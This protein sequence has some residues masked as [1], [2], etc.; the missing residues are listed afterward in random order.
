MRLVDV[1][2]RVGTKRALVVEQ[3]EVLLGSERLRGNV[4][5]VRKDV[6]TK[7]LSC[8]LSA[9]PDE[10]LTGQGG[11]RKGEGWSGAEPGL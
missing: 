6:S 2:R 4:T 1:P 5:A 10:L 8:S 7:E 11:P 3:L 9:S